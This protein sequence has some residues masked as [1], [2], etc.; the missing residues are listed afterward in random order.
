MKFIL[1]L[2]LLMTGCASSPKC[3]SG[4]SK[5]AVYFTPDSCNVRIK[6]VVIG[7]ELSV[8]ETL[9]ESESLT[10]DVSWVE[11]S[12]V[13]GKIQTGHFVLSPKLGMGR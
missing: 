10:H 7:S 4:T 1:P 5:S 13:A 9:K 11:T 2:L 3:G 6:D 12:V 8:P